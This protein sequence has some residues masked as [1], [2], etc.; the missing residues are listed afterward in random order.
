MRQGVDRELAEALALALREPPSLGGIENALDH[1]W[2]F[3]KKEVSDE[4]KIA[5]LAAKKR[6]PA[7]FLSQ[8]RLWAT[9]QNIDYLL[10]STALY[11]LAFFLSGDADNCPFIANPDQRDMDNDGRGSA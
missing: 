7:T 11:E 5:A 6:S 10:Q 9:R 3:L 1:M 8:I 2:G 4:A